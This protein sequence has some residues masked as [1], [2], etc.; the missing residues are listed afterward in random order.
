MMKKNGDHGGPLL[1]TTTQSSSGGATVTS[2]RT[3]T[4]AFSH[5]IRLNLKD[6]MCIKEGDQ[7]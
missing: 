1:T 7:R 4:V 3:E 2:S 6:Q 5:F